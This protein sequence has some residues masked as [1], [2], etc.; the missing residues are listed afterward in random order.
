MSGFSVY[1]GKLKIFLIKRGPKTTNFSA[2][3]EEFQKT[4]GQ[5]AV[6]FSV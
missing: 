1:S 4:P 3:S 6:F 5:K 2:Y